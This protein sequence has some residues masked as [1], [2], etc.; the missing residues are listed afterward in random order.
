MAFQTGQV[1][2]F[3]YYCVLLQE[4]TALCEKENSVKMSP[5]NFLRAN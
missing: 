3:K 4:G 2:N 1:K 5:E